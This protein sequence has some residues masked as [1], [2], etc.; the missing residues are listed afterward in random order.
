MTLLEALLALLILGLSA[1]GYLEVFRGSSRAVRDAAEWGRMVSTAEAGM[2]AA[3]LG[4]AL[5]AQAALEGDA[6]VGVDASAT[7]RGGVELQRRVELRPWA[8]REGIR[9]IVVTVTSTD[10][11]VFELRRLA[12]ERRP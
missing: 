3:T 10:G 12:R 6:Q 4:D 1:V 2:E 7:R 11:R 8:G 5:Q 9:E